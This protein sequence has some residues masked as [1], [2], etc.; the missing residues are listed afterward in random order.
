[1]PSPVFYS[2]PSVRLIVGS[3]ASAEAD[4]LVVPIFSGDDAAIDDLPLA[5]AEAVASLRDGR[6]LK[7]EPYET[8]WVRA[9]GMQSRRVLLIGA[10]P[11][12]ALTPDLA[13]RLGTAAALVARA[14]GCGRVAFLTRGAL[15]GEAIV[16][17]LAEGLTLA[18]FHVDAYKTRDRKLSD[19]AELAVVV[20]E[21]GADTLADAVATGAT[22]G[23][24]T[25]VARSFAH[26]PPNVLTPRV[27]AERVQALF[28]GTR[29]SVE[30]LEQPQLESLNMG[31]L[32]GVAQGSAEPPR[33]IVLTYTPEHPAG[34]VLGLVGKAVTFDTGG[35]SI[36]PADNMDRMKYDM[37]GGAAVVGAFHALA[38]MGAPSTVIGVVPAVENM[39]S[40]TAFRPGD[41]LTGASGLTV[42]I[43]NTDAEGRLILGDA[44]WYAQQLGATHLVDIATLTGACAVALGRVASGLFAAPDRWRDVLQDAGA[45]GGDMLWPL[46][47]TDDYKELLKSDIADMVNAPGTR[48]GGAISAALFLK[49]FTGDTPWAHLDIAGTAWA[50]EPKPW[51]PKGPTGVAV[52]TLVEVARRA[53]EWV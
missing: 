22:M 39:P 36:K 38:R 17:T 28:A 5:L 18:A 7:A 50:D 11:E 40:G 48:Y 53:G 14:R 20:S 6:E 30:V 51:Q 44:L 27:M 31:L 3:A 21:G 19:L 15:Q 8:H 32:L 16:R 49:A 2:T 46:P 47:M 42:E 37:C 33:L 25:N 12:G 23:E 26:E 13:R 41:I 4:V 52:R 24:A 1:M 35:I 29:V 45:R 10:G 34:P 9:D 43:T